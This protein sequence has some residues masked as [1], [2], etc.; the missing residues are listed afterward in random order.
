MIKT[1]TKHRVLRKTKA[2]NIQERIREAENHPR[3]LEM[4]VTEIMSRFHLTHDRVEEVLTNVNTR[5]VR[6]GRTDVILNSITSKREHRMFNVLLRVEQKH[7]RFLRKCY[8]ARMYASVASEY[9]L[10]RQ[11][12]HQIREV[13][14]QYS[15]LLN[16][17]IEKVIDK[18][19][20]V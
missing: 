12:A 20:N 15:E 2:S 16:L 18:I 8:T 6:E 7:P 4:K 17:P 1:K 3:I 19:E 10:S 5:L 13:L 14:K 11:R 9:N